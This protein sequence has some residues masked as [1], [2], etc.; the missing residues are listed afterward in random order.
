MDQLAVEW[1]EVGVDMGSRAPFL[2]LPYPQLTAP[3]GHFC[4]PLG[5]ASL[6]LIHCWTCHSDAVQ[7]TP[8]LL[9]DPEENRCY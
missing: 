7:W 4:Q 9:S 3:S 2:S 8:C 6:A 1:R 5:Y